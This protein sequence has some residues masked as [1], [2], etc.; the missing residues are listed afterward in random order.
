M[1]SLTLACLLVALTCSTAFAQITPIPATSLI[2]PQTLDF[3]TGAPAAGN[4]TGNDPYFTAF[5]LC[6]VAIINNPGMHLV[7]GDALSSGSTPLTNALCSV[8]NTLAIV[9][10]GGAMDGHEAGSGWTFRLA[11][12]TTATQ[13]GASIV[14]QTNH[15]MTVETYVGGVLQNTLTLQV[16]GA[17]GGF[18]N[19]PQIFEDLAGF[20]EIRFMNPNANGGWGIDD[21]IL[22]NVSGT[23]GTCPPPPATPF[24][25]NQPGCSLDIDGVQTTGQFAAVSTLLVNQAGLLTVQSNVMPSTLF[26]MVISLGPLAPSLATTANQQTLNVN[27]AGALYLNGNTSFLLAAARKPIGA[28]TF[29]HRSHSS[30]RLRPLPWTQPTLTASPSRRARSWK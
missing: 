11:P 22:A 2:S 7:Q 10:P 8:N 20:D 23:A 17:T 5:G 14:D 29:R 24:Q 4:I 12:G 16:T 30:P 19:D 6:N 9:A 18:P 1:R 13:F 28:A 21:L 25:I 3:D 26:E 15:M 27:L